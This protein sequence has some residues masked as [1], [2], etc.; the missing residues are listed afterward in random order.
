MSKGYDQR[1]CFD[2]LILFTRLHLTHF[3]KNFTAVLFKF[4]IVLPT[5]KYL[6]QHDVNSKK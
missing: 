4:M 1:A 2:R 3:I 5:N 6:R